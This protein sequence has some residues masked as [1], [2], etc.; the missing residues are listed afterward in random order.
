[1]ENKSSILSD[2]IALLLG[3]THRCLDCNQVFNKENREKKA[4]CESCDSSNVELLPGNSD[5]VAKHIPDR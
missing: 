4:V 3:N 2:E 1:M 5:W